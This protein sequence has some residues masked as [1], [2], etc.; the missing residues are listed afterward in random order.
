MLGYAYNLCVLF[1][2]SGDLLF[3]LLSTLP[4]LSLS[5]PQDGLAPVRERLYRE[6][7]QR[8]GFNEEFIKAD[9]ETMREVLRELKR[10]CVCSG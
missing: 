5:F 7:V 10:R 4:H 6:T 1:C 9:A 2:V 8:Y 3:H